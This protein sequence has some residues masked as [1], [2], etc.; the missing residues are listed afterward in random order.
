MQLTKNNFFFWLCMFEN[1]NTKII[2]KI[3]K[4]FQKTRERQKLQFSVVADI[5][6]GHIYWTYL[7]DR[8]AGTLTLHQK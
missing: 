5:S 1:L 6:T 8:C 3:Q 4:E 2:E 7:T